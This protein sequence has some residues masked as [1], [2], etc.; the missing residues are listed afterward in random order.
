MFYKRQIKIFLGVCVNLFLFSTNLFL[1]TVLVPLQMAFLAN[2]VSTWILNSQLP[3][4]TH[5]IPPDNSIQLKAWVVLLLG[6]RF[7]I[8][9]WQHNSNSLLEVSLSIRNYLHS[10]TYSKWYCGLITNLQ[11]EAIVTFFCPFSNLTDFLC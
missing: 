3:H 6:C 1:C 9:N 4:S 2:K 5:T 8:C 11:N 7:V 10:W